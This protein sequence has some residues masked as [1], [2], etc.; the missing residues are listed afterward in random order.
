MLPSCADNTVPLL[1]ATSTHL[2]MILILGRF[3]YSV[4]MWSLGHGRYLVKVDVSFTWL[5]A[6]F[7]ATTPDL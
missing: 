7:I 1:V 6:D 2:V 3:G 4:I 5:T